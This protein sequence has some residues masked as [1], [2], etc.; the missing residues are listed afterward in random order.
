LIY[1]IL[2]LRTAIR[3]GAFLAMSVQRTRQTQQSLKSLF[4]YHIGDTIL[5]IH[6]SRIWTELIDLVYEDDTWDIDFLPNYLQPPRCERLDEMVI[7]VIDHSMYEMHQITMNISYENDRDGKVFDGSSTKECL[8]KLFREHWLGEPYEEYEDENATIGMSEDS[9]G[10][11]DDSD[12]YTNASGETTRESE[13]EDEESSVYYE[14]DSN[15][16]EDSSSSEES[17]EMDRDEMLERNKQIW[18]GL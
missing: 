7:N 2:L 16:S 3:H 15:D 4:F 12:E 6:C 11:I 13:E 18:Q 1:V 17:H 14:W 10:I 5:N 9:S 8:I